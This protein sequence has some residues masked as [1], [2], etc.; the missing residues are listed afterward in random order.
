MSTQ[1][2]NDD[3]ERR[4]TATKLYQP[5]KIWETRVLRIHPGE[6]G[7]PIVI[8]LKTCVITLA[9]GFGILDENRNVTYEALSYTWG[10]PVFDHSISCNG[11]NFSITAG[12]HEALVN[13]RKTDD[14]RWLWADAICINQFDIDEKAVQIQNMFRIYQKAQ[15][16]LIYLGPSQAGVRLA[17]DLCPLLVNAYWPGNSVQTEETMQTFFSQL[18]P[19]LGTGDDKASN[20]SVITLAADGCQY[21]LSR[22]WI[23]RAW[24]MQE[25]AASTSTRVICGSHTMD[26]SCMVALPR[27][28][29]VLQ[30]K[31][32]QM[33]MTD[34]SSPLKT[35]PRWYYHANY[36]LGVLQNS[37]SATSTYQAELIGGTTNRDPIQG[38]RLKLSQIAGPQIKASVP[39]DKIYALLNIVNMPTTPPAGHLTYYIPINYRT[40]VVSVLVRMFKIIMNGNSHP[41][42][43]SFSYEDIS[44]LVQP[45]APVE[46]IPSWLQWISFHG[47]PDPSQYINNASCWITQN[48]DEPTTLELRG[49]C[50]GSI[51]VLA[52]TAAMRKWCAVMLSETSQR[53]PETTLRESLQERWDSYRTPRLPEERMSEYRRF[54]HVIGPAEYDMQQLEQ[55]PDEGRVYVLLDKPVED[56]DLL[57]ASLW[58]GWILRPDSS[59]ESSSAVRYKVV[60]LVHMVALRGKGYMRAT[61]LVAE[62][63]DVLLA[64]PSEQSVYTLV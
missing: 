23:F 24:V 1:T 46:S 56:G 48:V 45:E 47:R 63:E 55:M 27:V 62:L 15:N 35:E 52:D 6:P 17:I 7:D 16:V 22:P 4:K 37:R 41:Y 2:Q 53:G 9:Q 61:P 43:E 44:A 13:I 5:L 18:E 32:H 25:V 10:D 19:I 31:M 38:L 58:W 12:L 26:W 54:K 40:N 59:F 3:S 57:V 29:L 28:S 42:L 8:D 14:V 64:S 49:I 36:Q 50:V 39:L 51:K 34:V 30:W 60:E 11:I 20:Q 33:G 21:L